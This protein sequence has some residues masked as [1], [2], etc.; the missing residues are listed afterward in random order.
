[1]N[2]ELFFEYLSKII[3]LEENNNQT[4]FKF[5]KEKL[6]LNLALY[7]DQINE[8]TFKLNI[9]DKP[10]VYKSGFS[11]KTRKKN[12]D[13]L[14]TFNL[15]I[16]EDN[17]KSPNKENEEN[18]NNL[19]KENEENKNNLNKENEENKNNLNNLNNLNKENEENK[20]NLINLISNKTEIEK[21]NYL[22]KNK[23]LTILEYEI[24]LYY[25]GK[26]N[27]NKE[28][29]E[30]GFRIKSEDTKQVVNISSSIA[31]ETLFKKIK[32]CIAS[33]GKTSF[34]FDGQLTEN[35]IKD[36][37][38]INKFLENLKNTYQEKIS[39][40]NNRVIRKAKKI[41][42]DHI[43]IDP[44]F[45]KLYWK[46]GNQDSLQYKLRDSFNILTTGRERMYKSMIDKMKL[47]EIFN[48]K[49]LNDEFRSVQLTLK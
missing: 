23:Y 25:K 35:N 6:N 15:L 24:G 38:E 1:M 22:N 28:L 48:I 19:N 41:I 18:K 37:I 32:T 8:N 49:D 17:F 4:N 47:N 27:N 42:E 11:Y 13:I 20:N 14:F 43:Q 16:V 10:E 12:Q 21:L 2:K 7:P 29:I 39:N 26:D 9:A 46:D 31:R 3:Y 36:D 40:S 44:N 5:F 45:E 34:I 30:I 33:A